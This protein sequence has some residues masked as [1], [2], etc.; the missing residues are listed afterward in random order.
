MK[1]YVNIPKK[2]GR[3][4]LDMVLIFQD[5]AEDQFFLIIDILNFDNS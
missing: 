5:L 4:I 3:Y 2:Q 1:E